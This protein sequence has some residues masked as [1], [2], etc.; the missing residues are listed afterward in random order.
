MAKLAI[1]GGQPLRRRTFHGW[2]IVTE[3]EINAVT[4]VV[5]SGDWGPTYPNLTGRMKQFLASFAEYHNVDYAMPVT[6]GSTAIEV[7]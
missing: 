4:E 5:K 3:E 6:N 2:P 1:N 7:P